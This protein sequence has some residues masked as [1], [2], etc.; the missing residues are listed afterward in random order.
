MLERIAD[1]L[2]QLIVTTESAQ[3]ASGL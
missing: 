1:K 2:D 3:S